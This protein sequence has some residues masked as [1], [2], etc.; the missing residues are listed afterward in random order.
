MAH[1]LAEQ[2]FYSYEDAKNWVNS[3]DI[4]FFQSVIQMQTERWKK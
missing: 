4:L 3:K 1:G 2:R